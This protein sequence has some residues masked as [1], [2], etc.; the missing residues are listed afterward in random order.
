MEINAAAFRNIIETFLSGGT[1][2]LGWFILLH[3]RESNLKFVIYAYISFRQDWPE[4]V[5]DLFLCPGL[6]GGLYNFF[7]CTDLSHA[8]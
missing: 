8:V 4:P 3:K 6:V 5:Q 1:A 7:L 2:L